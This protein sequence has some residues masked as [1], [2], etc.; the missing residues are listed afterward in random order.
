[1][2]AAGV[3]AGLTAC[4]GHSRQQQQSA[5]PAPVRPSPDSIAK[6]EAGYHAEADS[7]LQRYTPA[8]VTFMSGM[9][10]HHA[11]AIA[12]AGLIPSRTTTSEIRTLG[13]RITN[14]QRDEIALMQ[15]WL[16]LR[17]L[18]V[19]EPN[20]NGMT[21]PGMDHPMLM[22]GML[23]PEQMDQLRAASGPTFD[24]LFLTFMIQHHTGAISMVD[25]LINAPAAALDETVFRLASGVRVDQSTE[26]G[27]MQLMLQAMAIAH[28]GQ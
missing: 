19:P 9:I 3:L 28:P 4:A 25:T 6:L 23:T 15:Q 26:I 5:A 1:V 13:S 24:R 27:R 2:F 20:P 11:Q 16:R 8:D 22:P 7:M 10:F 21:M 18:P 12:M 14:A 17:S